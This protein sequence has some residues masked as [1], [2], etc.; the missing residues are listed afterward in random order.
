VGGQTAS[1]L[2]L[3]LLVMLAKLRA[4]SGLLS[5]RVKW[6]AWRGKSVEAQPPKQLQSEV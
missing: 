4:A 3:T 2:P 6:G 1:T 5:A